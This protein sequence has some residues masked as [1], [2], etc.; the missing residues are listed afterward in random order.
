MSQT[1]PSDV[2]VSKLLLRP[3]FDGLG[4]VL[5]GFVLGLGVEASGLRLAVCGLD[6]KAIQHTVC[7]FAHSASAKKL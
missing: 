2:K 1:N 7:I 4:L 6:L 5:E 3:I